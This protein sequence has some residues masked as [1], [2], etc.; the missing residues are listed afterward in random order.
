MCIRDR[1]IY[2]VSGVREA[3][4]TGRGRVI[5]RAKAEIETGQT[6]DKVVIT[7][8]TFRK[9]GSFLSSAKC[10]ISTGVFVG[11]AEHPLQA[12]MPAR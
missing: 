7:E 10:R 8:G 6:H 3:Y 9:N 12:Q 4:L 2:G 11:Y 1:Y 5:M